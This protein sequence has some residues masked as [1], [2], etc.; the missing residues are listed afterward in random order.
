MVSEVELEIFNVFL[1]ILVILG[2]I[3]GVCLTEAY[4]VLMEYL[5]RKEALKQSSKLKH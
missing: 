2:I 3:I 5:K 4:H 1:W